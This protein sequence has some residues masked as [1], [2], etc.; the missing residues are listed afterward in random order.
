MTTDHG[1]THTCQGRDDNHYHDD[2]H[3]HDDNTATGETRR[4]VA[5]AAVG[6]GFAQG[7][8]G[9]GALVQLF[10]LVPHRK[11]MP[12]YTPVHEDVVSQPYESIFLSK[13]TCQLS[14]RISSSVLEPE[15]RCPD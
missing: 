4:S 14:W 8:V 3:D 12:S 15:D 9:L 13:M 7:Q 2:S 10:G 5:R 6:D 11:L 1:C